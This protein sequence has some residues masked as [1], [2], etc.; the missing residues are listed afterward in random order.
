MPSVPRRGCATF[1][2]R[3]RQGNHGATAGRERKPQTRIWCEQGASGRVVLLCFFYCIFLLLQKGVLPE[4]WRAGA[5]SVSTILRYL[6]LC[7]NPEGWEVREGTAVQRG[8]WGRE[9]ADRCAL[10]PT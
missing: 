8:R 5:E 2:D 7:A 9:V 6:L 10:V 1:G 3:G 4:P